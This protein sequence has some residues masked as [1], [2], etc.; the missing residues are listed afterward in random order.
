[1]EQVSISQSGGS[2]QPRDQTASLV[3]PASAGRFFTTESPGKPSGG[4]EP[5]SPTESEVCSCVMWEKIPKCF[6]QSSAWRYLGQ[7][8]QSKEIQYQQERGSLVDG[9]QAQR[10]HRHPGGVQEVL[11]CMPCA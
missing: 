4:R 5:A 8:G 2:S 1:M 9:D 6:L 10:L 11:L 7:G 3:F